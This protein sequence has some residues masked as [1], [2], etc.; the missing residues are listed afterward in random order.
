MNRPGHGFS[1]TRS[2]C[3]LL[4]AARSVNLT[5]TVAVAFSPR[6]SA[7]VIV[8]ASACFGFSRSFLVSPAA[9]STVSRFSL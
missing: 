4:F 8:F 2:F 5:L 7:L 6:L 9:S 3:V 1:L